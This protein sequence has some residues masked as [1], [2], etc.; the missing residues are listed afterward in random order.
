MLACCQL[1][2]EEYFSG[3]I[4]SRLLSS[5]CWKFKNLY[6]MDQALSFILVSP[7]ESP[8][9]PLRAVLPPLFTELHH[10]N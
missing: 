1:S 6:F 5:I 8:I 10:E 4:Y 2:T 9:G 3:F 7:S